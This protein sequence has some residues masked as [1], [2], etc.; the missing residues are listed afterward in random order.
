MSGLCN[1]I[2]QS[3]FLMTV[4]LSE[5]FPIFSGLFQSLVAFHAN[6]LPAGDALIVV[7]KSQ[8]IP[9]H[10][11]QPACP[12]PD[13]G[14]ELSAEEQSEVERVGS[15]TCYAAREGWPF[16]IAARSLLRGKKYFLRGRPKVKIAI[17]RN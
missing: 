13:Q 4:K 1:A 16:A 17:V 8:T 14:R 15:I 9:L 11:S 7:E 2:M 10:V 12:G 6:P 3:S 5:R